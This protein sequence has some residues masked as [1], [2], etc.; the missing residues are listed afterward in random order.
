MAITGAAAANFTATLE[1]DTTTV[2]EPVTLTLV[3]EGGSPKVAPTFPVIQNLSITYV[4]QSSQLS[5]V[6]GQSSSSLNLTYQ[7]VASQPG[8]YVIPALNVAVGGS[9]ITSQRLKLKVLKSGEQAGDA[10]GPGQIA[11]LQMTLPKKEVYV[12]E[13]FPVQ[14][15]LFA[16][17]GQLIQPPQL[18][19]EG[20]TVGK[21]VEA[22]KTQVQT[23]NAAYV[24]IS[25]LLPVTVIKTGDLKLQA[26]IA[27]SMFSFAAARSAT[28]IPF[29]IWA[30]FSMTAGKRAGSRFL[31]NRRP[32]TCCPC[33]RRTG[34]RIL[35]ERSAVSP[36]SPRSVRRISRSAI[37]LP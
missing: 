5:I 17:T 19:T 4:G 34:P 24:R 31:Q 23:N 12:G 8:D 30:T 20:M 2:G 6:N 28:A 14:I 29:S 27:S 25:Y 1:R 7:V 9:F 16:Q 35:A 26:A 37:R 18:K 11:F 32:F 33:Q 21:L 22:G 36:W 3:F 15:D 13:A 10:G